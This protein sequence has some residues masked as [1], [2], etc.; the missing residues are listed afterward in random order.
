MAAVEPRP[1]LVCRARAGLERRDAVGD[2]LVVDGGDRLG[3]GGGGD[4]RGHRSWEG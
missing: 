2:P 4:A 3:I 1:H